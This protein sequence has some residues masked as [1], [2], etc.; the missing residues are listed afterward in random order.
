MLRLS[1]IQYEIK[2][3]E[4]RL[5]YTL[6]FLIISIFILNKA[7][8][9][10]NIFGIVWWFD[11]LM[12]FS[13]GLFLGFL[14]VFLIVFKNVFR[15]KELNLRSLFL[16]VV[17]VVFVIGIGWEIFEKGI[18]LLITF[19]SFN[20][21]DTTSDI[22]FDLAGGISAFLYTIIFYFSLYTEPYK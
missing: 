9:D 12:H 17:L 21:L 6:L 4:N 3:K 7:A 18:D 2:I 14:G 1:N 8:L 10:Y 16:E 5:L 15:Q 11:M 22:F 20:I 13:G 19:K